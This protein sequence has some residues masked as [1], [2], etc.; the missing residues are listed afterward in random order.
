MKPNF[1]PADDPLRDRLRADAERAEQE[2]DRK[3]AAALRQM[4]DYQGNDAPR[5]ARELGIN[6]WEIRYSAAREL[7]ELVRKAEEEERRSR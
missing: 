3:C 1:I 2:G 6:A 4:A 5:H 7:M